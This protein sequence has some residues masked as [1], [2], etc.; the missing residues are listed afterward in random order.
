LFLLKG[1]VVVAVAEEH[2]LQSVKAGYCCT[3]KVV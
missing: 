1:V 3:F 2:H